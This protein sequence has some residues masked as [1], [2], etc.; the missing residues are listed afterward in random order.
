MVPFNLGKYLQPHVTNLPRK[1]NDSIGE[2]VFSITLRCERRISCIFAFYLFVL[3]SLFTYVFITEQ[4]Q[5]NFWTNSGSLICLSLDVVSS[6]PP[7]F[8]QE[9]HY[10]C[11]FIH[12]SALFI[13]CYFASG[14]PSHKHRPQ[15][16]A[17]KLG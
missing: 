12:L 14:S 6:A 8:V 15:I 9:S 11:L 17:S 5:A 1:D 3:D 2:Y 13:Y 4:T 16:N 10:T 7:T